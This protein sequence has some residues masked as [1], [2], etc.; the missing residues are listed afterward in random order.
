MTTPQYIIVTNDTFL[1][2]H[3]QVH[4]SHCIRGHVYFLLV[5]RSLALLVG[6]DQRDISN[7][8]CGNN[9]PNNDRKGNINALWKNWLEQ[10]KK[11][12]EKRMRTLTWRRRRAN[13]A[14][15]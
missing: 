1:Y 15:R 6:Q 5:Q 3:G 4:R 12:K 8:N 2:R 9:L 7:H 10:R 14:S 13:V 11:K